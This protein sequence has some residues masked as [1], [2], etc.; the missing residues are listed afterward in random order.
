M[1]GGGGFFKIA[2][3]AAVYLSLP[4]TTRYDTIRAGL[5]IPSAALQ[6]CLFQHVAVSLACHALSVLSDG[7]GAVLC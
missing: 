7:R 2:L 1:T 3:W 6:G 5:V 4:L